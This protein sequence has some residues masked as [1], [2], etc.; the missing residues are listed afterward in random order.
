[1]KKEYKLSLPSQLYYTDLPVPTEYM[2]NDISYMHSFQHNDP[3]IHEAAFFQEF[4]LFKPWEKQNAEE[5]VGSMIKEWQ[6]MKKDIQ[7]SITDHKKND[8]NRMMK[9][10]ILYF[11]ECLY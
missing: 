1:M 7:F 3:F 2:I 6:L 8:T 4:D 9:K 10:G 5:C 11:L